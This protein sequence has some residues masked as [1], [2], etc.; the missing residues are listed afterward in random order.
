[1]QAVLYQSLKNILSQV[2]QAKHYLY[3][4]NVVS[5]TVLQTDEQENVEPTHNP[6][7]RPLTSTRHEHLAF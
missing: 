2:S 4:T 7:H 1:M 5:G 6:A 3:I